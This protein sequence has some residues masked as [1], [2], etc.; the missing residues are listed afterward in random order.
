[1]EWTSPAFALLSNCC[2]REQ[3]IRQP[4][5]NIGASLE[6]V[7][8]YL[9]EGLTIEAN[10]PSRCRNDW[11]RRSDGIAWEKGPGRLRLGPS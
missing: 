1:M 4:I 2:S 5:K 3:A 11:Q 9:R 7:T 6:M 10:R 8:P